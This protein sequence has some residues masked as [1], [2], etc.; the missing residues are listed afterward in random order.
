MTVNARI[1]CLV[2]ILQQRGSD[3]AGIQQAPWVV[4]LEEKL[5]KRYPAS[6]L[7]LINRY[8]FS[9]FEIGGIRFFANTG[10][11]TEDEMT[12]AIFQDSIIFSTLTAKGYMQFARPAD[13]SYDPICFDTN[14]S[15]RNGEY[16]IV[17]IDH[18]QILCHSR[19][20]KPQPLFPSFLPFVIDVAKV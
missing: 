4:K 19:I 17:R 9:S 18:E 2:Q 12:Q 10:Q 11:H 7:S 3:I 15:V 13:G 1:D 20:R 14:Q 6:F 8:Q 16:P 5:P